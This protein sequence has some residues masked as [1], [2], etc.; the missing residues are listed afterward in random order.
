MSIPIL[1]NNKLVVKL[2]G[3]LYPRVGDIFLLSAGLLVCVSVCQP[4]MYPCVALSVC[5]FAHCLTLVPLTFQS[6]LTLSFL[7]Q[8]QA[9][10]VLP[11][12]GSGW[13]PCSIA[14]GSVALFLSLPPNAT[15]AS[16]SLCAMTNTAG[17][18]RKAR[19]AGCVQ[20]H[21]FI[22]SSKTHRKEMRL[23]GTPVAKTR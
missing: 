22:L 12:L 11:L 6:C 19:H 14:P 20:S 16:L 4:R 7:L 3:L 1:P 2:S 13:M 8:Q 21:P 5:L 15:L 17:N 18:V 10:C 9:V 23:D